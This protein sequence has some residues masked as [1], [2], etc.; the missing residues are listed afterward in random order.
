MQ[1]CMY[2]DSAGINNQ[3][4]HSSCLPE[5]IAIP[6]EGS[7]IS[8]LHISFLFSAQPSP[9]QL[10]SNKQISFSLKIKVQNQATTLE[11]TKLPQAK[12][13]SIT[14]SPSLERGAPWALLGYGV[15]LGVSRRSCRTGCCTLRVVLQKSWSYEQHEARHD[16]YTDS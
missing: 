6:G 5:A 2:S 14:E 11:V 3:R 13:G 16:R 12:A 8:A 9:R 7:V 1:S 4:G 10:G 15:W